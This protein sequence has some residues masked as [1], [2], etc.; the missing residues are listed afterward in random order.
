M[1]K[2]HGMIIGPGLGQRAV[3]PAVG[4][5]ERLLWQFPLALRRQSGD[6]HGLGSEMLAGNRGF[7]I[8]AFSCISVRRIKLRAIGIL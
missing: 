6:V 2:A 7:H 8:Q 4:G 3:A 5:A 1:L